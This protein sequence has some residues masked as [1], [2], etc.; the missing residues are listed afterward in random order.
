MIEDKREQIRQQSVFYEHAWERHAGA[1]PPL[2]FEVLGKFP[3]DPSI[4]Q[5]TEAVS[6]RKNAPKLNN[7]REWTN[8]PRPQASTGVNRRPQASTGVHRRPQA[9]TGVHRRDNVRN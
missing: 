4:R 1:V 5:A 8:E 9:S 3:S 7:K 2:K 6:I